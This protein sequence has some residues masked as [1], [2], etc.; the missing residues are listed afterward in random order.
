MNDYINKKLSEFP[1]HEILQEPSLNDLLWD[2]DA[3]S[4]YPFAMTDPKSIYPRIETGYAF[5]PDMNNDLVEKFSYQT[6]TQGYAI[7]KNEIYNP[8]NLIVQHLPVKGRVKKVET[9]RTRN[10][11]VIDTLPS[12][13]IQEI[14]R[15][16]GKVVKIYGGIV[17]R[18][19]F[20]ISPFKK[21]FD[22]LFELR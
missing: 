7:L 5:T 6:S 19:I 14:V 15:I 8:K 11:Y 17:H 1:I 9:N 13:D 22:K 21:V 2:F 4:L 20:S 3:V 18:K 16:G 10:G 12:V